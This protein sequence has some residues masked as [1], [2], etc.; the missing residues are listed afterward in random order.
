MG[1]TTGQ[2]PG[3]PGIHCTEQQL[4]ALSA[5]TG[6][7]YVI[8]NPLDFG[9]GEIGVQHQPG[10]FTHVPLQT[11]F[12]QL[13]AY[14]SR[15]A[16]LPDDSVIDWLASIFIPYDSSLTLVGN[17]QGCHFV[18]ANIGFGQHFGQHRALGRPDL[19]GVML[20]PARLW[21]VLGKLS[22]RGSD[23]VAIVIKDNRARTGGSL[24]QCNNVFLA[25]GHCLPQE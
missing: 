19:H 17:T 9:A 10:G 6:T 22:L 15:S 18:R 1:T 21:I 7:F 2:L 3:Q 24:V 25:S 4:T 23:N 12:F 14:L 8:E 11:G 20:N 16:A 13:F 5:F